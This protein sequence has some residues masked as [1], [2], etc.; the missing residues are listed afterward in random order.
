MAY[1][2]VVFGLYE[3]FSCPQQDF[4]FN[5]KHEQLCISYEMLYNVTE[6]IRS[7]SVVNWLL[8][9]RLALVVFQAAQLWM[10]QVPYLWLEMASEFRQ[11]VCQQGTKVHRLP[12]YYESFYVREKNHS[13]RMEE[14]KQLISYPVMSLFRD[15]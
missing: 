11:W 6:H 9:C 1:G 12:V 7:T 4:H 10:M 8:H 15:Q 13:R 5:H 3:Q 14:K 2:K